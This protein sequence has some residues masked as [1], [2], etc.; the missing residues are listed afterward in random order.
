MQ[1]LQT[2]MRDLASLEH[3]FELKVWQSDKGMD[4]SLKIKDDM[5]AS[6]W[7]W[8]HTEMWSKW[9]D[10]QE[11]EFIASLKPR[12]AP[13]LKVDKHGNIKVKVTVSQI[14]DP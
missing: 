9:S 2:T 3:K 1:S 4:A 8:S 13:K 14:S 10:A 11:K 6:M 12:K 5:D 7:A